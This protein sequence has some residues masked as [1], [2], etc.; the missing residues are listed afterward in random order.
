MN[1]ELGATYV[2]KGGSSHPG[3]Q[4]LRWVNIP[5]SGMLNSPGIR[6]LK[7]IHGALPEGLPAYLVLVTHEK[8][9][10]RGHNPWEDIVDLSYQ[11]HLASRLLVLSI[12]FTSTRIHS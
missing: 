12:A 10:A 1:Y 2:D 6:P 11:Y 9:A 4:F 7:N 8:S 3:D 5:G